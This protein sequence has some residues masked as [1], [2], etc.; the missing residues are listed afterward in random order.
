VLLT[1]GACTQPFFR[2][3]G[4]DRLDYI[5]NPSFGLVMAQ[6]KTADQFSN[7]R[8]VFSNGSDTVLHLVDG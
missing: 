8:D 2:F 3:S 1:W 6:L 5:A 7:L 4:A